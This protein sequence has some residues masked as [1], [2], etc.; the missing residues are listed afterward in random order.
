MAILPTDPV[1]SRLLI[2]A[3]RPLYKPILH[4]V[5]A[6]VAMLSVENVFYTHSNLDSNDPRDKIKIKKI[7]KRKKLLHPGSDHLSHLLVFEEFKKSGR[8]QG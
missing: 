4:S 8:S 2:T 6:I 3:L 7:K 5:C 1:Y